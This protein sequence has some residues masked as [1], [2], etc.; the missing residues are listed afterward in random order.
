MYDECNHYQPHCDC[1]CDTT[2]DRAE[3]GR[4]EMPKHKHVVE[5]H[6]ARERENRRV[7]YRPRVT[8]AF[9]RETQRKKN[10]NARRAVHDCAGIANCHIAKFRINTNRREHR[11]NNDLTDQN[12]RNA[13]GNADVNTLARVTTYQSV[14]AGSMKTRGDRRN[15]HQQAEEKRKGEKPDATTDRYRGQRVCTKLS[16]HDRICELHAGDSEV[17]DDQRTAKT[18]QRFCLRAAAE[19][20]FRRHEPHLNLRLSP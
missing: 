3:F 10:E 19:F 17:V 8:N 18:K 4:P 11:F 16:G 6:I 13:C 7:H 2:T 9:C 1:T 5:K 20:L 12:Q 15:R 14:I